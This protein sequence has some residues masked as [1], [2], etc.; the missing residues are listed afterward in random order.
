MHM[1]TINVPCLEYPTKS[2][3]LPTI[4]KATEDKELTRNGL[5]H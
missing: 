2:Q 1:Y 4:E 5:T 3:K